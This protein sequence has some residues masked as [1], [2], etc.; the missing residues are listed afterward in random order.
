MKGLDI[1]FSK[2]TWYVMVVRECAMIFVEINLSITEHKFSLYICFSG[3]MCNHLTI[4][5]LSCFLS[6]LVV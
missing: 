1:D 6:W 3:N 5:S 4:Y 2:E